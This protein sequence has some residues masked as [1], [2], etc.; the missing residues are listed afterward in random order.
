MLE[1]KELALHCYECEVPGS[2]IGTITP[3]QGYNNLTPFFKIFVP[4]L[5]ANR[6]ILIRAFN[7]DRA[8]HLSNQFRNE[9]LKSFCKV[10]PC[11]AGSQ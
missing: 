4:D 3:E 11:A 1:K 9:K 8:G 6:Y 7:G 10:F 5:I 2:S